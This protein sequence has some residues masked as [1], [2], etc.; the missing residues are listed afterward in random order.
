MGQTIEINRTVT[1]DEVLVV[2]TDRS[3][4]GQDGEVYF[5]D[6][7]PADTFPARLAGR[8]FEADPAIRHVHVMSNVVTVS[9]SGGWDSE[10]TAAA[11]EVITRFFRYY[12][13]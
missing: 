4:A 10:A 12:P 13:D 2:A 7:E 1:V 11:Q 6:S 5:P 9:R 3:L 8:L